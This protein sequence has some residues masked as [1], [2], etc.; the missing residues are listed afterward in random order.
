VVTDTVADRFDLAWYAF[1]FPH[2]EQCL[3]FSRFS[4]LVD[5]CQRD[6]TGVVTLD[7]K[8]LRTMTTTRLFSA[9]SKWYSAVCCA[10]QTQY[11]AGSHN[12]TVPDKLY[13]AGPSV[14]WCLNAT[15]PVKLFAVSHKLFIVPD[16][17]WHSAGQTILCWTHCS[18]ACVNGTVPNCTVL[19]GVEYKW[20]SKKKK[21]KKTW[22]LE[23]VA[24]PGFS[25]KGAK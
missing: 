11:C 22:S 8:C 2:R 10:M 24:S 19:F 4:A 17:Q 12:G 16:P 1:T 14:W 25:A 23:I 6:V 15:V 3:E 20:H 21:E 5:L 9:V 7:Y 18:V 13:C